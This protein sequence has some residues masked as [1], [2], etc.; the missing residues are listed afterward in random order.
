MNANYLSVKLCLPFCI[1]DTHDMQ[2]DTFLYKQERKK[3][4]VK[5]EMY[6]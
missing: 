4:I 1:H 5:I 3:N 2:P 6:E